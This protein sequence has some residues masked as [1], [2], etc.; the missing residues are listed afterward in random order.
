[1][2]SVEPVG[3]YV[4]RLLG[5]IPQ[6]DAVAYD[7][8]P[9]VAEWVDRY[10]ELLQYAET[11]ENQTAYELLVAWAR[12]QRANTNVLAKVIGRP[13]TDPVTVEVLWSKVA[14]EPTYIDREKV[15]LARLAE[16]AQLAVEVPRP[17]EWITELEE[18]ATCAEEMGT[19][20]LGAWAIQLLTDLDDAE[21][22]FWAITWIGVE[23][24]RVPQLETLLN[25]ARAALRENAEIAVWAPHWVCAFARA[26]NYCPSDER[27]VITLEK[28]PDLLETLCDYHRS[29]AMEPIRALSVLLTERVK[30]YLVHQAV[31]VVSAIA[32]V[33]MASYAQ[34]RRVAL[35]A[36]PAPP[37]AA[38]PVAAVRWISPD[39][40]YVAVIDLPPTLGEH[41]APEKIPLRIHRALV[42]ED[43]YIPAA[44]AIELAGVRVR[45]CGMESNLDAEVRAHFDPGVV[46]Q[47]AESEQAI[48][49]AVQQRGQW[50]TWRLLLG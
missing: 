40:Q 26:V 44:P 31:E 23:N 17:L 18:W 22:A 29:M 2:N 27:L 21:L 12:L 36:A 42:R 15:F 45:F 14:Q 35:A 11:L 46:L 7:P 9:M 37:S 8:A 5:K 49:F 6:E 47:V 16:L 41:D 4:D 10:F 38:L 39:Q 24:R 19:E 34:R 48:S 20:P 50:Q 43:Q 33:L 3:P 25:L 32:R 13:V 30:G 28:I 1:M